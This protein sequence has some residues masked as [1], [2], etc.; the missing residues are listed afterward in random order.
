MNDPKESKKPSGVSMTLRLG[1]AVFLAGVVTFSMILLYVT[2]LY[3]N[4]NPNMLTY[5]FIPTFTYIVGI[6]MNTVLQNNACGKIDIVR[7]ATSNLFNFII[8]LVTI[9]LVTYIP[10]LKSPIESIFPFSFDFIL[11]SQLAL[12]FWLFWSI[13]YSQ[14]FVSGFIS[15]C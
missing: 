15:I 6:I 9:V 5:I 11:K 12:A 8:P 4:I 10:L 14:V 1:L 7:V 13:L 3:L 2:K